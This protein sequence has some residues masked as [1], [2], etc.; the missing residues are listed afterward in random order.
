MSE[1]KTPQDVIN[2][3]LVQIIKNLKKS[4][5]EDITTENV[6]YRKGTQQIRVRFFTE[7]QWFTEDNKA[8]TAQL[9]MKKHYKGYKVPFTVVEFDNVKYY[10]KNLVK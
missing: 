10:V 1:I 3:Y 2:Y 9:L 8:T 7:D 4:G 5:I 6:I